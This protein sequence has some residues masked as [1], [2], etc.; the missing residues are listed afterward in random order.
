MAIITR[1]PLE[2]F[3]M[4]FLHFPYSWSP[5]FEVKGSSPLSS[6]SC[7]LF[8]FPVHVVKLATDSRWLPEEAWSGRVAQRDMLL[9]PFFAVSGL[10]E[11]SAEVKRHYVAA[12]EGEYRVLAGT[13]Q[14]RLSICRVRGGRTGVVSC[15]VSCLFVVSARTV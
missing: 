5:S 1:S 11:D 8:T 3:F 10:L 12:E 4:P 6:S 9:G 14:Q 2:L 15:D 7:P 13:L